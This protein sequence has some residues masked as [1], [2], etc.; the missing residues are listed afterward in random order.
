MSFQN[1]VAVNLVFSMLVIAGCG[2]DGDLPNEADQGSD[3]D[4]GPDMEMEPAKSTERMDIHLCNSLK[5]RTY[6]SDTLEPANNSLATGSRMHW[7][8]YFLDSGFHVYTDRGIR[9]GAVACKQGRV[10]V[11]FGRGQQALSLSKDLSQIAYTHENGQE[12]SYTFS[13]DLRRGIDCNTLAGNIYQNTVLLNSGDPDHV[14]TSVSFAGTPNTAVY[15]QGVLQERGYYVC[16][17]GLVHVHLDSGRLIEFDL[18]RYGLGLSIRQ[19]TQ[20]ATTLDIRNKEAVNCPQGDPLVCASAEIYNNCRSLAECPALEYRTFSSRCEA[21]AMNA[22]FAIAGM[23]NEQ[24]IKAFDYR[25]PCTDA[26]PP[27]CAKY[28]KPRPGIDLSLSKNVYSQYIY[29]TFDNKCDAIKQKDLMVTFDGRCEDVGLDGI[30]TYNRTPVRLHNVNTPEPKALPKSEQVLVYPHGNAYLN[31]NSLV[32]K[33]SYKS[34]GS[35]EIYFNVDVS[36]APSAEAPEISYSFS[37]SVEDGDKCDQRFQT[38]NR[39]DLR[40]I[41][42]A[43]KDQVE[44]PVGVKVLGPD[45]PVYKQIEL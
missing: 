37:K 16:E 43:F 5:D 45:G 10:Y 13:E 39:Y 32:V 36:K 20:P 19:L 2:G 21:D 25:V 12:I 22:T 4:S 8:L 44:G 18:D 24:D 17:L 30:R 14:R 7:Q 6:Y 27:V 28:L 40:P 31:G 34:C 33:L 1:F 35:Q 23:C 3:Q 9:R 29:E 38:T 41:R 26:Y 15:T 42:A 11:D